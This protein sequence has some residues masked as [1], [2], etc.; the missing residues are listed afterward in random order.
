MRPTLHIIEP[1]L[2]WVA[3]REGRLADVYTFRNGKA[4]EFRTFSDQ[5]QA[6][7]WAGVKAPTGC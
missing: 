6:L 7:E 1:T 5:R 3:Q 2:R 4:I